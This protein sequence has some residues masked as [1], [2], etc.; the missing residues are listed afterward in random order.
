MR[1]RIPYLGCRS[2]GLIGRIESRL[3]AQAVIAAGIA[4]AGLTL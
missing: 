2:S 1:S 3:S 4:C